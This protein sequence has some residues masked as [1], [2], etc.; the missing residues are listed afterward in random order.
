MPRISG[1]AACRPYSECLQM[2]L[3]AIF[4]TSAFVGAGVELLKANM[5]FDRQWL[6]E[7][8]VESA[9]HFSFLV[10]HLRKRKMVERGRRGSCDN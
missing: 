2:S 9:C 7:Y 1:K 8:V 4:S 3:Y 6:V 10:R 5:V